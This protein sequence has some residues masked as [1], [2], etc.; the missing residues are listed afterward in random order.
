MLRLHIR[1]WT[2]WRIVVALEDGRIDD[3]LRGGS[4]VLCSRGGLLGDKQKS[5]IGKE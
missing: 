4:V 5:H 3:R 2:R 1:R